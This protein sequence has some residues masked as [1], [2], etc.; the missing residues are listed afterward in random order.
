MEKLK[1]CSSGLSYKDYLVQN[2]Y[3][4]KSIQTYCNVKF[5]FIEWCQQYGTTA[6]TIDYKTFLKYIAHLRTGCHTEHRRSIKAR[7]L[8]TYI[9]KLKIYFDYLV[10]ENYR[11]ENIIKELHIKGVKKTIVYNFYKYFDQ[12]FC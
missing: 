10:A 9:G 8:K 5:R 1:T 3:T 2:G 12:V 6:E 4:S 11:L 7:T